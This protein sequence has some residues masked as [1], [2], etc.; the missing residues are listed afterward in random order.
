VPET[1]RKQLL[2]EEM[3]VEKATVCDRTTTIILD[4]EKA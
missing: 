1:Y 3:K 4:A 2:K